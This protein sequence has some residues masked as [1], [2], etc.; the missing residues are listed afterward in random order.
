MKT[1]AS[2][3]T[4]TCRHGTFVSAPWTSKGLASQHLSTSHQLAKSL[5]P[6]IPALMVPY[7][8]LTI[9]FLHH[10]CGT[11]SQQLSTMHYSSHIRSNRVHCRYH[12]FSMHWALNAAHL[13]KHGGVVYNYMCIGGCCPSG[14]SPWGRIVGGLQPTGSSSP[15]GLPVACCLFHTSLR[16][17]QAFGWPSFYH[18][19]SPCLS[20]F[21]IPYHFWIGIA[22][23]GLHGVCSICACFGG[24]GLHSLNNFV[25]AVCKWKRKWNSVKQN[26][27]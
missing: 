27:V 25:S 13:V 15:Q 6:T 18:F 3:A 4:R 20:P 16:C 1:G 5:L 12:T 7:I 26:S 23:L 19:L 11:I 9:D 14:N 10:N 8:P 22:P 21:P 2:D 17:S 24:R